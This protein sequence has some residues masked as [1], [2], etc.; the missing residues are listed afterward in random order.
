MQGYIFRDTYFVN[1]T[2]T[3]RSVGSDV[4]TIGV[5]MV[6]W[7]VGRQERVGM[8]TTDVEYRELA[9]G[10]RNTNFLI[11][12]FRKITWVDLPAILFQDNMST[13]YSISKNKQVGKRTKQINVKYHYTREFIKMDEALGCARGTV[14]KIHTDDNPADITTKCVLWI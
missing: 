12:L 2:E 1:Y 9:K 5:M 7:K 6:G 10:C 11:M 14:K 8:S 13:I 4:Q 3:R